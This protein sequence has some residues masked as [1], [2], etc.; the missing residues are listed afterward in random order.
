M[1]SR[2]NGLAGLRDHLTGRPAMEVLSE[3]AEVLRSAGSFL[4]TSHVNVDGDAVGSE[5][6]L[7]LALRA[8][9]KDVQLAHP[10][11]VPERLRAFVPEALLTVASEDWLAGARERF[12]CCIVLDTSEPDRV[13]SLQPVIFA[14]GQLRI[15]IDHHRHEA[16]G[17]Y[18]HHLVVCEVP[19]TASLVLALIDE[20][21][22]RIDE[23]MAR[24]LWLALST[25]T[26]WFRFSNTTPLAMV[27]G[28]RLL[29]LGLDTEVLHEEIYGSHSLER[30]RLLG[31]V[32]RSLK[33][34]HDN[35]FVW[36]H[37]SARLLNSQGVSRPELDGVIDHLKSIRGALVVALITDLDNS[38]Y[39]G[40][41]RSMHQA[42]VDGIAGR[43]GGGGHRK[44]AG[45]RYSGS[46]E[47]LESELCDA[48]RQELS[49]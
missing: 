19:A 37:V 5:T 27:D 16:R 49:R 4:I 36:G 44:A 12:D 29:E 15:C 42:D 20:L 48:V 18:A 23:T 3:I 6:A 33:T 46:L 30:T 31:E 47:E 40:S 9:G 28:A 32:L 21:G 13:G 34:A 7:A 41:L 22:V 2:D 26:G 14:E 24:A 10:Q 43:F 1:S 17:L 11:E 25:D 38:H 8:L 35:R 39:K 45:F